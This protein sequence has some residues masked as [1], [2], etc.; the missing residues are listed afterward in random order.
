ME[1]KF[2]A[3]MALDFVSRIIVIAFC[4]WLV[5]SIPDASY[6]FWQGI[7]YTLLCLATVGVLSTI[8]FI[9]PIIFLPLIPVGWE[10]WWRDVDLFSVSTLAWVLC[11]GVFIVRIM[12]AYTAHRYVKKMIQ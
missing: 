6:T 5:F 9:G 12:L 11:I 3:V 4:I 2:V 7:G 10:W 8:P 1:K